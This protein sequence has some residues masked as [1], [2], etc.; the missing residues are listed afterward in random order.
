LISHHVLAQCLYG[1]LYVP[2]SILALWS[3]TMAATT[4]PGSVPMGARPLPS[5]LAA[6]EDEN[7]VVERDDGAA[8]RGGLRR[9]R[10]VRRCGKCND[11]YKPGRAHHDSVTGRCVVKMDHFCP[12][13]GNAVGIMNH[14]VRRVMVA[15]E[16]CR[17]H[18]A[19]FYLPRFF[20]FHYILYICMYY[21]ICI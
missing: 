4:D 17:E 11:N 10:G 15:L 5:N 7:V 2:P 20:L 6:G 19:C 9:R 12:W 18:R 13:V 3:L 16:P 1:F 21:I 14:K 8:G